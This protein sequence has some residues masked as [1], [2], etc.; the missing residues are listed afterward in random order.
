MPEI[1]VCPHIRQHNIDMALSELLTYRLSAGYN[2][3]KSAMDNSTRPKWRGTALKGALAL[4]FTVIFSAPSDAQLTNVVYDGFSYDAGSLNGQNGG[5]GWTS[6]WVNDYTSGT[7]FQVSLTGMSYSGLTTSGGSLSWANG[8]NGISEDSRSLPLMN[9]GVVFIQFLGQF[10]SSSGGG[11]PNIRLINSGAVTGGFGGNGGPF[12]GQVSILDATLN[13]AANGSSSSTANL[14]ALNL[15]VARIDYQNDTTSLWV[16]PNL[17]TF[18]YE[19][20][21]TPDASYNGLAPAF[22]TVAIYSR[23]PASVDEI[24]V[25]A[26]PVPEPT[27]VALM[28]TSLGAAYV[29]RRRKAKSSQR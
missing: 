2:C 22:D 4:A 9:S 26:E 20:P 21:I 15:V 18:D 17:S 29:C 12:G 25:K 23:S 28:L 8:G 1:A 5:A 6:S 16:N 27:A 24:S 13:P 19:N 7:S 14:S 3:S 10:G 11:T